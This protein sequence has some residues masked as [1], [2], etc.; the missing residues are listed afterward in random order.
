[1]IS[2]KRSNLKEVILLF[3]KLGFTTFGGPAAYLAIVHD[4]VVKRHK[5]LDD[6]QFLD[7]VGATNLIPGPNAVEMTIHL[8]YLRAGWPGLIL[9]GISYFLPASLMAIALGW[10]YQKYGS[11][12]QIEGVLF[13]VKPV[14]I[15]IIVKALWALGKQAIKDIW[16]GT[17]AL[18]VLAL[19]LAGID[20]ILL[21]FST[22]A[23]VMLIKNIKNIKKNLPT[24][25]GILPWA[26]PSLTAAIPRVFNL[27][28]LFLTFIKISSVL[29]GG[30]YVLFAFLHADFVER[31]GWLTEK[32][33]I[34]AIAIGQITPGPLTS[35]ATFIGWILG[36]GFGALAATAGI[37]VPSFI[38]VAL[39]NH[40]IPK[41]R[42][43]AW[44]GAF[45]DGVNAASLG[46]MAAVTI[47]I[48]QVVFVDPLSIILGVISLAVFVF[49][50]VS[51]TWVIL[52][53]ILFG[54][55]RFLMGG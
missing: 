13:A 49:T 14:I 7:L 46:L 2:E 45:L 36:G 23:L 17:A 30:G 55:A 11:A 6:E 21:L 18:G 47:Q 42:Q 48:A 24:L 53:V 33:L 28:T 4:E 29:Y 43:S 20:N 34:D 12:P 22:G 44:L 26:V 41:M 3:L 16:T 8:S 52:T 35:T 19:N 27:F 10:T 5:W 51:T 50:Q 40:Y 37:F 25:K 32:Q 38:L 39:T 31:L 54:I 1:M 15:A 9:G